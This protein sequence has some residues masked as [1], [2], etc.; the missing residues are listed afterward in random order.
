MQLKKEEMFRRDGQDR[1]IHCLY[2]YRPYPS[3]DARE[4]TFHY[5]DYIELL[6]GLDGETV[7]YVGDKV[8]TIHKGDLVMINSGE[9]HAMRCGN[10]DSF[11]YVIKFLPN[12]L[13]NPSPSLSWI[14]RILPVWQSRVTFDGILRSEE[15]A[16][17]NI[18]FLIN[19]I[20]HEW[21]D[22]HV[23]YELLICGDIMQIFTWILRNHCSVSQ[24]DPYIPL[25]LQHTLQAIIDQTPEHLDSWSA[26]DAARACGL[27]YNYFCHNFK[28]AFGISYT[29]Y[30]ESLRLGEAERLL[31]T[32]D[33]SVTDI[34]FAVGFGTSSYFIERFRKN[35]GISPYAF[36]K[37]LRAQGE[38]TVNA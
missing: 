25:Q 36:R 32:T 30:I 16:D 6:Y 14:R 8:Y 22:R 17:S 35:Y 10:T 37:Q 2:Q 7:A 23:G 38:N 24:D 4:I 1:A 21:E 20:I 19:S 28:K 34:A 15:I 29:A 9:P 26:A 27:S 5:H 11:Y 3:V 12:I 18:D 31:L 13:Y 33:T